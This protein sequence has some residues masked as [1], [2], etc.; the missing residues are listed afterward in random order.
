MYQAQNNNVKV[1]CF[2]NKPKDE[3]TPSSQTLVQ[4]SQT[5]TEVPTTSFFYLSSLHL[6]FLQLPSTRVVQV[7]PVLGV[8]G[9]RCFD[10]DLGFLAFIRGSLKR[11]MIRA[12]I[13]GNLKRVMITTF[14]IGNLKRFMITAFIRGSLKR[15]MIRAFIKGSLKRVMIRFKL[16]PKVLDELMEITDSTEL[17]KRMRL[18]FVQEIAEEEGF[19]NFLR[20]RCD[21]LR[22]RNAE[23]RVL[24]GEMEALGARGVAVDSLDCWKQT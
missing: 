6:N 22:R 19:L 13:R 21:D 8:V 17:H 11:V 20:D 23:R 14:T 2:F 1:T 24:I 16:F 5:Q 7:D 12:F 3:H 15:V 10:L 4:A 9:A 18:W